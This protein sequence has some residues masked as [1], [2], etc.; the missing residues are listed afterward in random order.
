ML[1]NYKN[2]KKWAFLVLFYEIDR[3]EWEFSLMIAQSTA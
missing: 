1:L 2:T 3:V